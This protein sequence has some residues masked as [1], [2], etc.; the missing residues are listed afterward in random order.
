MSF[1]L[2]NIYGSCRPYAIT[3]AK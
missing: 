3:R 1:L 2:I